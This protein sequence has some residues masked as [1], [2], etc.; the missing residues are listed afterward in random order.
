L[1]RPR[2]PDDVGQK[3][4]ATA[5][6][7]GVRPTPDAAS[8]LDAAAEYRHTAYLLAL[9]LTGDRE[10][11]RDVAQDAMVRF[12]GSRGRLRTGDDA[13]PWLLTIVRNL[14]RDRWRR[15]RTRPTD[16]LDQGDLSR[17]LAAPGANPEQAAERR[18]LQTRV[19]RAISSLPAEKREILV[20]RDFHDLSYAEIAHVVGIPV[21]TVMSRLHAARTALREALTHGAVR[22]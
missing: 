8:E 18:E 12:L 16:S 3:P 4:D 9:H 2:L 1:T 7:R 15:H 19:W 22:G 10:E 11:A 17:E 6:A 21:G 13:R 14:V 20:L 5:G